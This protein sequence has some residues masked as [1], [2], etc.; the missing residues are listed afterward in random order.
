MTATLPLERWLP[1]AELERLEGLPF[2]VRQL[3]GGT[4][5]GGHRSPRRGNSVEFAQHRD[6][7]AGDDLRYV[8][9]KAYAKSDRYYIKL[10]DD[11]TTLQ[12]M[13]AL[14]SSQ[15]MQYQSAASLRSKLDYAKTVGALLAWLILR[16]SDA[17]GFCELG[18]SHP[19]DLLPSNQRTQLHA[20]CHRLDDCSANNQE[21]VATGMMAVSG[22]LPS[23]SVVLVLSDF[24]EDLGSLATGLR[25]LQQGKHDV[26]LLHVF[27]PAE[28][29]FPFDQP[30]RFEGLE[31]LG[32]L[33]CDA[34]QISVSYREEFVR[35]LTE[36]QSLARHSGAQYVRLR[37]DRPIHEAL[38]QFLRAREKA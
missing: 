11:E 7:T 31:Q 28:E 23:R 21:G 16:Q 32:D 6:Y 18:G 19:I 2:R 34:K 15:S 29:D 10:F 26:V 25:A 3:A 22:R 24:F 36:L 8:D 12:A 38:S 37:T 1:A 27:D 30:T 5:A 17:V 14:D 20:V 35:F 4:L 9:W 33:A 13:L